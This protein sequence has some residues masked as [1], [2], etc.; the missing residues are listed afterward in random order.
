MDYKER[1]EFENYFGE[2]NKYFILQDYD[3][4]LI[5]YEA[6]LEVDKNN[7]TVLYKIGEIYLNL[8]K[9]FE[10]KPYAEAAL[11]YQKGNKYIYLL[12]AEVST[13]TG[14]I[15]E[16][17]ETYE[18]LIENIPN[19]N[20]YLFNL[21]T[22]YQYK[23]EYDKALEVLNEAEEK[24]G[25]SYETAFRKKTLLLQMG[26]E[27]EAAKELKKLVNIYPDNEKY[28]FELSNL[29]VSLEQLD[30]AEKMVELLLKNDPDNAKAQVMLAELYRKRGEEDKCRQILT[31]AVKN[32]NLDFQT[33]VNII[34][35]Y[36]KEIKDPEAAPF[37][38]SMGNDII[39]TH[40]EEPKSH[41][42]MGDIYFQAGDKKSALTKYLTA[43]EK[44][45]NDFEVWQN[46]LNLEYSLGYYEDL[47]V[48]SE[49]AMILYPNQPSVYYYAGMAA[50]SLKEYN[51]AALY[52][53]QAIPYTNNDKD[54]QAVFYGL[55][56]DA[57]HAKEEFESA[58][59]AYDNALEINPELAHVLNNY[60]YFLAIRKHNLEKAHKMSSKLIELFPG[61]ARYLDTHGWVLFNQG[62]YREAKTFLK[63]AI[64]TNDANA[65][66]YEH[67]GDV[68]YKLGE[69]QKAVEQWQIAKSKG[70]TSEFI[71]KKI[72][73]QRLYEN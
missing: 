53:E 58:Y 3:T 72:A 60:S 67:Y 37:I 55:K 69:K 35:E 51:N 32:P 29:Y 25:V 73:E 62:K 4:A 44:E 49:E 42:L 54:L 59:R 15:K 61:N 57:Y 63:S 50:L 48:H 23:K 41:A 13:Q 56:G 18:K 28:I 17:I 30:Q 33:K 52:F 8:G 40:P 65:T 16:A 14:D 68:L 38:I 45:E 34:A 20:I 39:E 46:I 22:L 10:A 64:D 27:E 2:G 70:S 21:S 19:S 6:A 26:K 47:K 1:R 71:D 5:L 36:I 66:I 7:P 31:E 11:K 9:P 12:Y 43:I 24:M